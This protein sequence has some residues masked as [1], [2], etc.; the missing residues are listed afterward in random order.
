MH[1]AARPFGACV[2]VPSALIDPLSFLGMMEARQRGRAP[3]QTWVGAARSPRGRD[4]DVRVP[5]ERVPG[6]G[7]PARDPVRRALLRGQG[8]LRGARGRRLRRRG[9]LDLR[10]RLVDGDLP[11]R[12]GVRGGGRIPRAVDARRP[13]RA[14]Q[15]GDAA[16]PRRPLC[17]RGGRR[18]VVRARDDRRR[19]LQAD[20][21]SLRPPGRRR[22]PARRGVDP[23]RLVQ[24][25]RRA[26]AL[27]RGRV[28][29]AREGLRGRGG[30]SPASSRRSRGACASWAAACWARR[31]P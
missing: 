24:V 8:A 19:R 27:R 9:V 4:G 28:H 16:E 26:G 12:A 7:R 13:D 18:G 23:G 1:P 2:R 21:R 5:A 15:Q 31:P 25:L 20:Q 14:R 6:C 3:L 17:R 11:A 22:G 10:R 29:R 30:R